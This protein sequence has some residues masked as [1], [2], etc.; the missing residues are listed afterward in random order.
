MWNDICHATD[1]IRGFRVGLLLRFQPRLGHAYFGR[2]AEVG[3]NWT[4]GELSACGPLSAFISVLH[5]CPLVG[6]KH[7]VG[8]AQRSVWH[9]TRGSES[10][11]FS[12]LLALSQLLVEVRTPR[13]LL[14]PASISD[15]W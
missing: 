2:A 15:I 7:R 3:L 14:G 8:Q 4:G 11:P 10:D 9:K 6:M 12:L 13:L 1:L 5:A